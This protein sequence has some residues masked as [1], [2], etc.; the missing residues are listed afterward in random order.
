MA[1]AT[2][3]TCEDDIAKICRSGEDSYRGG[4]SEIRGTDFVCHFGKHE[5]NH[6]RDVLSNR[7]FAHEWLIFVRVTISWF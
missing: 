1:S 4:Y 2:R 5:M 7:M 3:E 6:C